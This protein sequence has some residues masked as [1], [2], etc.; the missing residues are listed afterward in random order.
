VQETQPLVEL[1]PQQGALG[2]VEFQTCSDSDI[3]LRAS[4]TVVPLWQSFIKP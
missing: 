3:T 2:D 4:I 1:G